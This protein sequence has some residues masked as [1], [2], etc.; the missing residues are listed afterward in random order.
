MYLLSNCRSLTLFFTDGS[1]YSIEFIGTDSSGN[2]DF[3]GLGKAE[4]ADYIFG[5]INVKWGKYRA[6]NIRNKSN[7]FTFIG[8]GKRDGSFNLY[9]VDETYTY[10]LQG[11]RISAGQV[12]KPVNFNNKSIW[13]NF[14]FGKDFV[15]SFRSRNQSSPNNFGPMSK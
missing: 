13:D 9:S 10:N 11:E 14:L 8:P 4:V 5:K 3:S 12:V 15:S 7:T 2:L 6:T 1:T